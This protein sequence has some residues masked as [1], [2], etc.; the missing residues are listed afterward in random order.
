VPSRGITLRRI[1]E[2]Q[3]CE[4]AAVLRLHITADPDFNEERIE[5]LRKKYTR[6]ADF[7]KEVHIVYEALE[8]EL[9]YPEYSPERNDCDPFD[10][11]DPN[12]WTIWHGCD[13]HM[14]T[15]NAFLWWATSTEG[16]HAIC[17]ELWT[18]DRRYTPYE[19]ADTIKWLESDSTDKPSAWDWC[20]GKK[21]HVYYR[22]MDTH[23]SAANSEEGVDFFKA[24]SRHDLTYYP[25]KK[26]QQIIA[27][28][29]DWIG[30]RML[31]EQLT[32]GA[33]LTRFRVFNTL[34][35]TRF[36]FANVRYPSGVVERQRQ[37]R[38]E[39]YQKHQI[40][41]AHYIAAEEPQF[42]LQWSATGR[43]PRQMFQPL[44]PAAGY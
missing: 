8:G 4:G 26:G 14:R 17:G 31:P 22:V 35:H 40:D 28:A 1:P 27:A 7:Q 44:N 32:D 19:C 41:C 39:T 2:G 11:S 34:Q 36:Q 42:V 43:R 23:G 20:R 6:D 3:P 24:F 9:L 30:E 12:E 18:P 16:E 13:P 15:P 21:L 25:A 37:E 33:Q 10:V 29:R 38:P 5:I